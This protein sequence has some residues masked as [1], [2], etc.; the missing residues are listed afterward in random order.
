VVACNEMIAPVILRI[1]FLRSGEAGKRTT[2]DF[3]SDH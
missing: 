2:H 3:A 1:A